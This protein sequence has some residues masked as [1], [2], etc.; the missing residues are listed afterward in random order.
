M[1]LALVEP[2]GSLGPIHLVPPSKSIAIFSQSKILPAVP[3]V[4]VVPV[5]QV[6][7]SSVAWAPGV[8]AGLCVAAPWT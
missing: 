4:P 5:A 8:G 1:D 7:A 2:F 6:V 3:G